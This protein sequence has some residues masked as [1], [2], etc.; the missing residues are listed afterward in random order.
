MLQE[1]EW[2]GKWRLV[3]E[4]MV[5]WMAAVAVSSDDAS[6]ASAAMKQVSPKYVP[7]EWML[8]E[9]YKDAE[10]GS[11]ERMHTLHQL[12]KTPYDEHPDHESH[13]YRH[14]DTSCI[15]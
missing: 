6:A 9:A 4:W 3:Q 7:H 2:Q 10:K 13:Y 8:V 11:Y 14:G 5:K 15:S 12:L 1:Q